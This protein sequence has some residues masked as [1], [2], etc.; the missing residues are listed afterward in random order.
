MNRLF[1]HLKRLNRVFPKPGPV[2]RG[3]AKGLLAIWA[4]VLAIAT[5]C[6]GLNSG[7]LLVRGGTPVLYR[8]EAGVQVIARYYALTDESLRFVKLTLPGDREVT[9]PQAL[10]ASGARYSD[11]GEW[12]WWIKGD[13]GR[14]ERRGPDG[15]WQVFYRE[16]RR[17]LEKK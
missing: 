6:A 16:C 11:D 14:L 15:T 8:C 17:A 12:V 9:L 13:G 10:S 3:R 4:A 1:R 5:G 7:G 2:P